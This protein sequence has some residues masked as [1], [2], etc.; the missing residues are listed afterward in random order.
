MKKVNNILKM[1]AQMDANANEV[2]LGKHE[3]ELGLVEDLIKLV[4]SNKNAISEASRYIDNV[5]ITWQKLYSIKDEIDNMNSY[6]KSIPSAKN[7]LGFN[8]QEINKI[9][10]K[11]EL[12]SKELGVDAKNVKGYLDA[13]KE[14]EKNNE[15]IKQLE[16]QKSSGEKILSEL[17]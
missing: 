3:V 7:E 14:I 2:K 4:S 16:Q 17:K 10:S 12:Q 1:I 13:Q 11:I 15:Y 6:I 8:N 5:K 9:L